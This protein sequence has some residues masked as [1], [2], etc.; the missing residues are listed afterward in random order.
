MNPQPKI[1]SIFICPK[2]EMPMTSQLKAHLITNQGI[3]GDRYASYIGTFSNTNKGKVR[4]ITLITRIGIDT[5][6]HTL[7]AKNLVSFLDEETRRNIVIDEMSSEELNNLVGKIFYLGSIRLKGTELC[8]PCSHP[9]KLTGKDEF[10]SAF[11]GRG[12]IRAQVLDTGEISVGD[13]LS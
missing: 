2:A 12:G 10:K 1:Q 5:A 13:F 8:D 6:N 7:S 9:S 4:D 3:D 11:T